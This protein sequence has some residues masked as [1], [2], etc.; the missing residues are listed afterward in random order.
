M[1]NKQTENIYIEKAS[2]KEEA[3]IA[4]IVRG[5]SASGESYPLSELAE[6]LGLDASEY[7]WFNNY[8]LQSKSFLIYS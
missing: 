6:E 7:E 1:M 2:E 8:S 5:R 3:D 4:R